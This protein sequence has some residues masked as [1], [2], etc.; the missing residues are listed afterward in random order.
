M[1]EELKLPGTNEME[2]TLIICSENPEEVV[3]RIAE[4][5][6][7]NDYRIIPQQTKKIHDTYFDNPDFALNAAKMALRIREFGETRL[8]TLK[9][10]S[11]LTDW[12]AVERLEVEQQWGQDAL[13]AIIEELGNKKIHLPGVPQDFNVTNP[14]AAMT[15]MGLKVI[16]NRHTQRQIRNIVFANND[17]SPVLAELAIDSVVYDFDNQKLRHYEV[18]IEAKMQDGANVLKPVIEELDK[19]FEPILRVWGYSKL[20]T[21]K[22]INELLIRGDLEDFFDSSNNLKPGAYDKIADFLKH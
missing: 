12:G 3:Q 14:L 4:L 8:I 6:S 1:T 15:H 22:A 5:S 21:G 16:Q 19:T 18:E 20:A 11:Q 2:A 9:G 13:M 10:P 7:I 17:D